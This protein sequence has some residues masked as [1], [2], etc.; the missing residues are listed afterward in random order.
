MAQSYKEYTGS[1]LSA[2]TYSVDFKYLRI[3]DV[4][5]IGFDGEKWT[6]LALD[7]SAPR[8]A[9]NKTVTLATAPSAYE[10]LRIYRAT[11]NTQLVDFQNGSRL[12]ESDLDT[13]YQQGLFVAQEVS[14]DASTAQFSAVRE[15]GLQVGTSLSNF[16][17]EDFTGNG[18]STAFNITEFNPQTT[19]TEAYR[20]SIDGVM[21]SP[22]D[23][24]SISMTPSKITFTSAPPSGS[25][26]VVVTAASAASAASVD[27]VTIGLTSA[28]KTEIKDGGITPSKL[29]TGAPQWDSNGK[30][31]TG[32]DT[33]D[34]FPIT[35][36]TASRVGITDTLELS[37]NDAIIFKTTYPDEHER[38]RITSDG[39]LLVGTGVGNLNNSGETGAEIFPQGKI[40]VARSDSPAADFNRLNSSGNLIDFRKD[41]NVKG[42]I[43][44]TSSTT[45]YNTSSDYRLKEDIIELDDS[46][47][48]LKTLKPCNF[49]WKADGNRVDGFIAHEAQEVVP[50]AVTGTK[51]AVDKEGNPD[52]QGI[53]QS[54][55]IPLLTKALQEAI[56]KIETLEARVGALE[57]A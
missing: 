35:H 44:I 29:S 26:I 21:Q 55:L 2:T 14:E 17:S 28:N 4:H 7:A 5:A 41:G 11:S 56:T 19:V 37:A 13:A 30:L 40:Q 45:S 43:T 10:K 50:E 24:Y 49:R 46:T 52:Y 54:K 20:V 47:E 1:N 42:S 16:A 32:K 9:T 12:S 15:A 53:D 38:M 23:A 33:G 36:I 22:V 31:K 57:N 34:G 27:D 18:T 25:K 39:R 48:R 6:P 8:S 51:D 3:D